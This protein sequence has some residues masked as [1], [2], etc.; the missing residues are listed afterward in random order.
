[1]MLMFPVTEEK[2]V[3]K[4]STKLSGETVL[5]GFTLTVES[6]AHYS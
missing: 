4:L 5:P 6:F 3:R 1:M 2:E